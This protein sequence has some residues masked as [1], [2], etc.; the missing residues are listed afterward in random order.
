MDLVF[1]VGEY[2]L[3]SM[4]INSFGIQLDHEARGFP[5]TSDG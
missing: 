4:V 1:T 5:N 3:V 2:T